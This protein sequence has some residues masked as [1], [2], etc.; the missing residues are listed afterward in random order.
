MISMYQPLLCDVMVVPA[1]FALGYL[2]Y[3]AIV[4]LLAVGL[5]LL[6]KKRGGRK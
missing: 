6:L 3:A 5:Y 1:G 2:I 4:I